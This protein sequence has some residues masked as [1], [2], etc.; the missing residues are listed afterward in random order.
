MFD[1]KKDLLPGAKDAIPIAV[2][3]FAVSFSLGII[4]KECGFTAIEGFF[5]SLTTYASAGQYLGYTLYAA[6]ATLIQLIIMTLITNARYMLMGFA[7]AQRT[8]EGTSTLHR[9]FTGLTITDE[10][11]GITIAR[12]GNI[13]W[14]YCLGAFLF[15][16]PFW[17]LGNMCGI[18]MGN[19]LPVNIVS[20]FSVALYGMFIAVIVPPSRRDKH[21][22]LFVIIAFIMSYVFTYAPHLSA[23]SAGNRTI[24]LTLAISSAA[25]LIFPVKRKEAEDV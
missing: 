18:I 7:L 13:S 25:A 16:D 17:A 20:A 6:N 14:A 11:F 22:M 21:V 10:I 15:A 23:L 1:T 9:F 2:G 5:A 4:A 8:P 3:Y 12:P 24:I 19:V